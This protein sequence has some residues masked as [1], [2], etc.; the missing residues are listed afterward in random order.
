MQVL[1]V[2]APRSGIRTRDERLHV[3]VVRKVGSHMA[4]QKSLVVLLPFLAP[5][6]QKGMGGQ[7]DEQRDQKRAL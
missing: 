1:H 6:A 2:D 5:V 3:D 7:C 4:S